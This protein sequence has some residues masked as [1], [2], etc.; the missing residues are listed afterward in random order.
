MTSEVEARIALTMSERRYRT[1][2]ETAQE[3]VVV[4]AQDTTILFVN[5]K[6][7]EMLGHSRSTL[8]RR[9]MTEFFDNTSAEEGRR[10]TASRSQR[11][12]ERYEVTYPHPDGR[13]RIFEVSASPMSLDGP[14]GAIGSL[15][16]ISDVTDARFAEVE[17]RHRALHDPL[18]GLPN[19]ALF[20][21]RL[22]MALSRQ[23]N[24]TDQQ[25]VAVLSI[26]LDGFKLINGVHGHDVGDAILV[27]VAERLR[28]ASNPADTVARPGSDEFV[29][30]A[31]GVDVDAAVALAERM[32]QALLEPIA[33]DTSVVYVD[34]SVGIALSP[35]HGAGSLLRSA[36]AALSQAKALGRARVLVHDESCDTGTA[37]RLE[38]ATGV[39]EALATDTMTLGYQPIVDLDTG[40]VVG[41]EA[42]LRWEHPCLG[43]VPP[44]DVVATAYE[45]GLAERL[46]QSVLDRACG[47]MAR[48]GDS[49]PGADIALSVNLSS[50]S[51]TSRLP[52]VVCDVSRRTGWPLSRV[53]LEI[54]E[55]VLMGNP[56]AAAAV[57][58]QLR[59]L[60]VSVAIDDFGTG[61]S[62]L[63]YLKQLPVGTLKVD[64]SFV[65]QVPGDPG[66][67]AI[68]RSVTQLAGAL[69]LTTVAE[70]IET[71]EQADFMHQ[72]GC[73][74]GQGY[75]WS[76]AVSP[77]KLESLLRTWP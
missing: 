74:L 1:I 63:S 58:S 52:Q 14:D 43:L 39:R 24:G 54:T 26:D 55:N 19:R 73:T 37:R 3:G 38:M 11:G 31:E 15:A 22:L 68:A 66:S 71:Q 13:G 4:L 70:G 69:S 56:L 17:L 42:L 2:V 33:T 65:E 77:A 6:A 30:I 51:F 50:P 10:R 27:E 72:L 75:L 49:V 34:A 20:D 35:P 28:A 18:T 25:T 9:R 41:V 36:D 40:R 57:L 44:P 47:D 76:P 16:M 45:I 32:R 62:S 7:A 21:D 8:H 12:H 48:L 60:G 61:Y 23:V 59:D 46:D 53:T 67:C 5:R 64:R 29:V